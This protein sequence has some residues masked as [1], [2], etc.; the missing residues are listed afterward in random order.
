MADSDNSD[1]FDPQFNDD[2]LS[3]EGH[4]GEENDL[5]TA[6]YMFEP[7]IDDVE[8]EMTV[9]VEEENDSQ[10]SAVNRLENTSWYVVVVNSRTRSA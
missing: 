6:P 4:S 10:H 2:E 1:L 8:A 9:E 3:E 7:V 5:G